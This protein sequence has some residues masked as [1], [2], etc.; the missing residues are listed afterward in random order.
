MSSGIELLYSTLKWL[1][2]IRDLGIIS[3]AFMTLSNN[4][5]IHSLCCSDICC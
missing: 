4:L 1:I 3:D 5:G 2:V